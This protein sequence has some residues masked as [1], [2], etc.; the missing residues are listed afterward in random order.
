[1]DLASCPT[2][3]AFLSNPSTSL[4]HTIPAGAAWSPAARA[5][6]VCAKPD[7]SQIGVEG[8]VLL[9]FTGKVSAERSRK[10]S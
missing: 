10:G 5:W 4:L 7:V 8:K 9:S 3:A 2:C 1:M 6:D